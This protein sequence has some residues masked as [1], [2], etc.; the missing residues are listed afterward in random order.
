LSS[1]NVP[2][3]CFEMVSR[4]VGSAFQSKSDQRSAPISSTRAPVWN[5]TT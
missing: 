1:F 5:A 4:G 2:L 3:S